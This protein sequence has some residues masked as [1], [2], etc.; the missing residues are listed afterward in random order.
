LNWGSTAS[1]TFDAG[2]FCVD[3]SFFLL[4]HRHQVLCCFFSHHHHRSLLLAISSLPICA[5]SVFSVNFDLFSVEC[6]N[7]EATYR[8]KWFSFMMLPFGM[9][10]ALAVLCLFAAAAVLVAF[11][12]DGARLRER[13]HFV[14]AKYCW[15]MTAI[16]NLLYLPL[17]LKALEILDCTQQ[18]D[19][20]RTLDAEPDLRC[21]ADW[22]YEVRPWGIAAVI[23]FAVGI[24]LWFAFLLFRT[25]PPLRAMQRCMPG[26]Y[27][28]ETTG[29]AR[30]RYARRGWLKREE[31]L[32]VRYERWLI[33]TKGL[34]LHLED[35]FF[36]W[37]LVVLVRKLAIALMSTA[38]SASPLYQ[39]T[40]ALCVLFVS[41]M[42]QIHYAP[43][44][45][46]LAL[47]SLETAQLVCSALVLFLGCLMYG[48]TKPTSR[49]LDALS[50]VILLVIVLGLVYMAYLLVWLVMVNTGA[51]GCKR[52]RGEQRYKA[53]SVSPPAIVRKTCAYVAATASRGA[54]RAAWPDAAVMIASLR[55]T[56]STPRKRQPGDRAKLPFIEPRK[57]AVRF[58]T[59]AKRSSSDIVESAHVNLMLSPSHTV[60]APATTASMR[61]VKLARWARPTTPLSSTLPSSTPL[62]STHLLGAPLSSAPFLGSP[63]SSAPRSSLRRFFGRRALQHRPS[64]SPQPGA[65][66][67]AQ[68]RR[69]GWTQQSAATGSAARS[70]ASDTA[71]SSKVRFW[72]R[73]AFQRRPPHKS[74]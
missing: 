56:V 42:L 66:V 40:L 23:L 2:T 27:C 38:L 62:A 55:S 68:L 35:A 74:P 41:L 44:L 71:Y 32:S 4:Y 30:A 54:T 73:R 46:D 26:C 13:L 29:E 65:A 36:Y 50:S 9:A 15:C 24:P 60:A 19:G 34:V 72:D 31:A 48:E 53:F 17:A 7:P 45:H 64:Q 49:S 28:P 33:A 39:A 37:V 67:P 61:Y 5:A 20:S 57:R 69:L 51:C 11:R 21:D 16:L 70:R 59:N 18:P 10:M 52:G 58:H 47:N 6:N 63:V 25:R 8:K 1:N 22:W 3:F 43:Y 12:K 14:F